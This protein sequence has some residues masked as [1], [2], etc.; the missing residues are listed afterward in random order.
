MYIIRF[1]QTIYV[2]SQSFYIFVFLKLKHIFS[3]IPILE[4]HTVIHIFFMFAL[5]K[6]SSLLVTIYH[7]QLFKFCTKRIVH[8]LADLRFEKC[9]SHIVQLHFLGVFFSLDIFQ[10]LSWFSWSY[11]VAP[12]PPKKRFID[13]G[14]F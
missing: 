3:Y 10:K 8:I 1:K 5:K 2:V 6:L 4:T 13:W 12:P 9:S 11:S 7:P 14:M